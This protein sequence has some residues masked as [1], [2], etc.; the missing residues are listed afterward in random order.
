MS[1]DTDLPSTPERRIAIEALQRLLILADR[2]DLEDGDSQSTRAF[3]QRS[4]AGLNAAF[5]K[6]PQS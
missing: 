1:D 6:E 4:L 3:V 2:G 5:E